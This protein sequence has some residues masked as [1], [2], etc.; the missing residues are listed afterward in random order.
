MAFLEPKFNFKGGYGQFFFDFLPHFGATPLFFGLGKVVRAIPK[1]IFW[2]IS[3]KPVEL[4]TSNLYQIVALNVLMKKGHW[5]HVAKFDSLGDRSQ[6]DNSLAKMLKIAVFR[7]GP[8][9][10]VKNFHFFFPKL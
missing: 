5:V 9:Q 4:Q 1:H 3:P 8:P 2:P 7:L 6:N 10:D